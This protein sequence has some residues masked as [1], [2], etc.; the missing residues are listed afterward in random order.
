MMTDRISRIVSRIRQIEGLLGTPDM[1]KEISG[2]NTGRTSFPIHFGPSG[3]NHGFGPLP[4]VG[5]LG[6][7]DNRHQKPAVAPYR[8][9]SL[10]PISQGLSDGRESEIDALSSILEAETNQGSIGINYSHGLLPLGSLAHGMS[11]KPGLPIQDNQGIRA[12]ER[13]LKVYRNGSGTARPKTED[14]LPK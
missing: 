8:P 10:R 12:L 9:E 6:V 1:P 5:D 13:A 11:T 7:F 14:L 3:D 2:K 4:A